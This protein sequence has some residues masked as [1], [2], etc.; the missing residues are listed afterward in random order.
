MTTR[1]PPK[2]WKPGE[3][4]NPK[5][6]LPGS[7]EVAK[8]RAGIAKHVPGIIQALVK[9]AKAGDTAAARLLLERVVAPVKA[10]ELPMPVGGVDQGSLSDQGRALLA[11]AVAGTL[12]PSYVAD[13]L[14]ALAAQARI[15]EADEFEKR[16]RA[17]E[18]ATARGNDAKP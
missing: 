8:L 13:L 9:Q 12:P 14:A 17:L 7:G 1:T 16:L 15:V 10:T 4:G 2:P 5:G 6:R 11:A 18:Q 3:S